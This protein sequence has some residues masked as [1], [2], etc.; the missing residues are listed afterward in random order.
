MNTKPEIRNLHFVLSAWGDA[1]QMTRVLSLRDYYQGQV[2][3][4]VRAYYPSGFS[5]EEVVFL[6]NVDSGRYLNRILAYL[7]AFAKLYRFPIS[8]CDAFYVYGLDNLIL[9]TVLGWLRFRR[10]QVI[11]EVDDVHAVLTGHSLLNRVLRWIN[12]FILKSVRAVVVTSEAFVE[13]FYKNHCKNFGT[14]YFLMENKVHTN[15]VDKASNPLFIPAPAGPGISITIGYFGMI[16][17]A[18]SLETLLLLAQQRKDIRVVLRGKFMHTVQDYEARMAG[19]ENISYLGTY[20]S[21]V[22]LAQMYAEIDVAWVC[23]PYHPVPDANWE[24][25]RTNRFY[26]SGYYRTPM[27][28]LKGTKDAERVE[29]MLLG[30]SIDLSDTKR[31]SEV[32]STLTP[33][34]IAAMR[35]SVAQIPAAAFEVTDDYKKL[36]NFLQTV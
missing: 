16:R 35:T 33:S 14:P 11:Y 17:C 18:A 36:V 15:L 5:G 23:Y 8:S 25:A 3:A 10:I 4:Y 24:W 20:V 34:D 21:P 7:K 6:A 32:L 9:L 1:H 30:W 13:S 28:A 22:D 12:C 2:F 26:E 29:S 31:A 27:I 19:I